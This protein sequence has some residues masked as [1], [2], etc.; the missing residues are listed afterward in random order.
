MWAVMETKKQRNIRIV[1]CA[2]IDTKKG[3]PGA[4]DNG[5]GIAVLLT[6]A[7]LLKAYDGK[8]GVELLALNGEDYYAAPGQMQYLAQ[9]AESFDQ[10]VLAVNIDGAGCKGYKTSYCVFNCEGESEQLIREVFERPENIRI[11][12][13][14]QGDHMLFVMNRVPAVAISSENPY[15]IAAKLAHTPMD[16]VENTDAGK[17]LE[18]A[19]T[20]KALIHRLGSR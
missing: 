17:I 7:D 11:D 12:P 5:T 18:I 4:L 2:H 14:Y 6:L 10:I 20:L 9:N 3:T 1:I 19:N 8:Y 16:T 15:Q 13:W